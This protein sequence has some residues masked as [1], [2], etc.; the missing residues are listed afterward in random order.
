MSR[1]YLPRG[2]RCRP[3]RR[4]GHAPRQAPPGSAWGSGTRARI[5]HIRPS[6]SLRQ[7]TAAGSLGNTGTM[8]EAIPGREIRR[9]HPISCGRSVRCHMPACLSRADWKPWRLTI[10]LV[11]IRRK[12]TVAFLIVE[13]S[14]QRWFVP[15]HRGIALRP[16]TRAGELDGQTCDLGL[17]VAPATDRQTWSCRGG[18]PIAMAFDRH[19]DGGLRESRSKSAR[20]AAPAG[21]S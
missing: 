19:D 2:A 21:W 4:P 17:E 18:Q 8:V 13:A 11:A 7:T 12:S 20:G 15:E 9:L 5:G 16:N 3:R 1:P 6:Q 14:H 10:E